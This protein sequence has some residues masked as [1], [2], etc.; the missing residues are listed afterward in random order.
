MSAR[1]MGTAPLAPSAV[2]RRMAMNIGA[3]VL[4]ALK[5]VRAT[6]AE[7]EATLTALRPTRSESGPHRSVI[8]P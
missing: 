1:E 8:T 7:S 2:A 6:K 4:S 3:L 5:A